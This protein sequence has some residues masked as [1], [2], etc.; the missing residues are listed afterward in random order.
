MTPDTDVINFLTNAPSSEAEQVKVVKVPA[1]I[2]AKVNK[3]KDMLSK[4]HVY[5][6]SLSIG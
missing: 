3:D 2:I 1:K 5:L 4:Q 6:V